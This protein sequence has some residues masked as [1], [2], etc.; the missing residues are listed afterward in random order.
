MH[1]VSSSRKGVS[2]STSEASDRVREFQATAYRRQARLAVRK[3]V[4]AHPR[5]HRR[6]QR[7]DH[8]RRDHV[9]PRLPHARRGDAGA[10][11]L[12]RMAGRHPP[13]DHHPG[14]AGRE[15]RH[16]RRG[17]QGRDRR[18]S[19]PR[20][21]PAPRSSPPT[22][23]PRCSS[24]GSAPASTSATCP[25]P[26]LIVVRL[27]DPSLVDLGDLAGRLKAQVPGATLDDHRGMDVADP[28][29]GQRHGL[30][31]P[32]DPHSGLRRHRPQR[33]LRHARR[34]GR[35]IGTWSRSSTSSAP[36]TATSPANSSAISCSSACAAGWSAPRPRRFL[37]LLLGFVLGPTI[38]SANGEQ[39]SAL[40][41]RFA[42]GPIGYFGALGIAFL[43][44]VM[45]AVTSRLTVYRYLAETD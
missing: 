7:A 16:R 13:R 20:R 24:R 33:R 45:T 5:E 2:P 30:R 27:S 32:V 44:A 10:R 43:I 6:R 34:D 19:L 39:V 9:L 12:A 11:C 31:R 22:R 4:A 40:F 28:D 42:V 41:G 29:H 36:R 26:R 18:A 35:A 17:G 3:P 15:P 21:R 23:A 8:R 37:F 14:P 1:G 25:I 38:D